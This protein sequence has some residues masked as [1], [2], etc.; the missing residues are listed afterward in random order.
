MVRAGARPPRRGAAARRGRAQRQ[1]DEQ[2]R[3]EQWAQAQAQKVSLI[4]TAFA[5]ANDYMLDRYERAKDDERWVSPRGD[6]ESHS[7]YYQRRGKHQAQ[8]EALA[9]P[10]RER[11]TNG[12]TLRPS[13]EAHERR[14]TRPSEARGSSSEDSSNSST[15][16][17]SDSDSEPE[18][19]SGGG[20]GGAGA[21][22]GDAKTTTLQQAA[23]DGDA[24]TVRL[25]LARGVD[26]DWKEGDVARETAL[27]VASQLGRMEIVDMLLKAGAQVDHLYLQGQT[28][29]H[30][31]AS[32]GHDAVARVLLLQGARL[33]CVDNEGNTPL[34]YAARYGRTEVVRLLI[35]GVGRA[36]SG[37]GQSRGSGGLGWH[38][39]QWALNAKNKQGKTPPEM[40][41]LCPDGGEAAFAVLAEYT[42]TQSAATAETKLRAS[43]ASNNSLSEQLQEREAEC[44]L[45][46]ARLKSQEDGALAVQRHLQAVQAK[47]KAA[48]AAKNEALDALQEAETRIEGLTEDLAASR[49][50]R[51]AAAAALAAV[52]ASKSD[53]ATMSAAEAEL[54]TLRTQV[55]G[56]V[57]SHV[58]RMLTTCPRHGATFDGYQDPLLPAREQCYRC[59]C[60]ALLHQ[61]HPPTK[62]VTRL[63]PDDTP[64]SATAAD[65]EDEAAAAIDE[66]LCR[67]SVSS[68][69]HAERAA[70]GLVGARLHGLKP[71]WCSCKEGC[72]HA[73]KPT[74][75]PDEL[76]G[77]VQQ[78]N[79]GQSA[80]ALIEAEVEVAVA[81]VQWMGAKKS[82]WGAGGGAPKQKLSRSSRSSS[83]SRRSGSRRPRSADGGGSATPFERWGYDVSA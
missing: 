59:G 71:Q 74:V 77:V 1:T 57:R 16:G 26:V 65:D 36:R 78:G 54:V 23:T 34:H 33:N 5:A 70:R 3:Q 32:S 49:R 14:G 69:L 42:A 45:L 40:S 9:A 82:G 48:N 30:A 73:H 44:A 55:R 51:R 68:M 80:E 4:D 31:A 56:M 63:L 41:K 24:E 43:T 53:Q 15:D 28:P 66:P 79:A 76:H 64:A 67:E 17:S 83:G 75:G 35:R 12:H 52:S 21:S 13:S 38:E 11:A 39:A 46:R 8:I 47:A 72:D 81:S 7:S 62:E 22:E 25:L 27:H 6:D 29:L 50:E 60:S 18:R 19:G 61:M 10:L 2:R 58:S 37:R 20:G